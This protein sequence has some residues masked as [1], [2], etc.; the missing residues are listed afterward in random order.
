M[1]AVPLIKW[2]FLYSDEFSAAVDRETEVA[3]E[4][5]AEV[6]VMVA[7]G[8]NKE[9]AL[10]TTASRDV[11]EWAWEIG[12]MAAGS[13]SAPTL[14]SRCSTRLVKFHFQINH[15]YISARFYVIFFPLGKG[16]EGGE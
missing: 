4:I 1:A 12:S 15:T 13:F 3:V 5:V 16:R 2:S 14:A 8:A 11:L 10:E 9:V 6:V 7:L